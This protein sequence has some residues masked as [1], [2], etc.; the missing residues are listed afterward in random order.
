LLLREAGAGCPQCPRDKTKRSNMQK[1]KHGPRT[2]QKKAQRPRGSGS[3]FQPL[4]RTGERSPIYHIKFYSHG[5][6]V[7]ESSGSTSLRFAESLL[8]DRLSAVTAKKFIEPHDRRAYVSEFYELLLNDYRAQER[9][10]LPDTI[11]RWKLRLKKHFDC[12][13][14]N[15]SSEMLNK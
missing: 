7:R 4:N 11:R 9:H 6:P 14:G 13:A 3:I 12:L 5:K 15:V 8:R 2:E 10:T 1:H